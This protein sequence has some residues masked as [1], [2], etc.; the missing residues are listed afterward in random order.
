MLVAAFS[1][2]PPESSALSSLTLPLVADLS[3]TLVDLSFVFLLPAIEGGS[4]Q[5]D[6]Y[7]MRAVRNGYRNVG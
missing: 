6:G 2:P 3:P 7:E 5:W 1:F 4:A